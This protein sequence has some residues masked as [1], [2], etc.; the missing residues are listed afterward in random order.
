M[1]FGVQYEAGVETYL[2]PV[3]FR[4]FQQRLLRSLPFLMRMLWHLCLKSSDHLNV[5]LCLSAS[6]SATDLFLNPFASPVLMTI[7]LQSVMKSGRVTLP[8]LF[9][10]YSIA[11]D[12]LVPLHST[13]VLELA[14][15]KRKKVSSRNM[16]EIVLNL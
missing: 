6:F 1:D 15:F 10:F 13:S 5:D 14:C 9:S 11:L 4:L 16:I 3:D 2:F 7:A 8:T 12:V